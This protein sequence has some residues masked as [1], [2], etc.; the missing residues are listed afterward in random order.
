MDLQVLLDAYGAAMYTASYL[1]KHEESKYTPRILYQLSKH[2]SHQS[3]KQMVRRSVLSVLNTREVSVQEALW[4]RT[5]K[6][7]C[8]SSNVFVTLPSLHFS[9][10][11][12]TEQVRRRSVF[13]STDG[14]VCHTNALVQ[15]Y[16]QRPESLTHMT[17]FEYT[18]KYRL[19]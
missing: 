17:L 8:K 16:V 14:S 12:E 11:E 1:T 10:G 9:I 18:T 4:I 3:V 7:F 6:T 2:A 19:S 13:L 15:F 5:G